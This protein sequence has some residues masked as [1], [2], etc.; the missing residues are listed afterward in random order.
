MWGS[1]SIAMAACSHKPLHLH[2]F[3]FHQSDA[4]CCQF[5]LQPC[6][7]EYGHLPQSARRKHEFYRSYFPLTPNGSQLQLD[8][9]CNGKAVNVAAKLQIS[10]SG[11]GEQNRNLIDR[12]WKRESRHSSGSKRLQHSGVH[13][14]E[15]NGS[16]TDT[17]WGFPLCLGCVWLNASNLHAAIFRLP[18]PTLWICT[19]AATDG[20]IAGLLLQPDFWQHAAFRWFM[21]AVL[22]RPVDTF[23]IL[24]TIS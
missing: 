7:Q 10:C 9:V 5:C 1:N 18:L 6:H 12:I 15:R 8:L 21:A 2:P 17:V 22:P 11:A 24:R 23:A 14:R 19:S 3:S 13:Y 4:A 20:C 16:T